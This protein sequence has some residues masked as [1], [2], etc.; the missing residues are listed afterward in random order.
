MQPHTKHLSVFTP[1]KSHW[2]F[3]IPLHNV[4]VYLTNLG[5]FCQSQRCTISCLLKCVS[6]VTS[7][8]PKQEDSV[9]SHL[10]RALTRVSTTLPIDSCACV[11]CTFMKASLVT[12][13][14][15]NFSLPTS[16]PCRRLRTVRSWCTYWRARCGTSSWP[17]HFNATHNHKHWQNIEKS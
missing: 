6:Q 11:Q 14:P 13:S 7:L 16:A 15:L 2:S 9:M 17:A 12:A 5:M 4:P 3:G 8:C 1:A 10:I